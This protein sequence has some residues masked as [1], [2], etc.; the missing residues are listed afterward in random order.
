MPF[1]IALYQEKDGKLTED[2]EGR[3]VLYV[4]QAEKAINTFQAD[5]LVCHLYFVLTDSV[6]GDGAKDLRRRLRSGE[7]L[8][9]DERDRIDGIYE[10]ILAMAEFYQN[11]ITS[12]GDPAIERMMTHLR[13]SAAYLLRIDQSRAQMHE[14]PRS[15]KKLNTAMFR[16]DLKDDFREISH[17]DYNGLDLKKMVASTELDAVRMLEV[18]E[19]VHGSAVVDY[20]DR[21]LSSM[22]GKGSFF[23]RL[24]DDENIPIW[25]SLMPGQISEY[26]SGRYVPLFGLISSLTVN[27]PLCLRSTMDKDYKDLCNGCIRMM[28]PAMGRIKNRDND[29]ESSLVTAKELSEKYDKGTIDGVMCFVR[30]LDCI[31]AN[32]FNERGKVELA[33]SFRGLIR[34]L[35]PKLFGWNYNV[36]PAVFCTTSREPYETFRKGIYRTSENGVISMECV[37]VAQCEWTMGKRMKEANRPLGGVCKVPEPVYIHASELPSYLEGTKEPVAIITDLE[38]VNDIDSYL[39]SFTRVPDKA[40]V[41][42]VGIIE[43]LPRVVFINS[44][45]PFTTVIVVNR[46]NMFD[47]LTQY[48]IKL[49][50]SV[51]ESYMDTFSSEMGVTRDGLRTIEAKDIRSLFYRIFAEYAE[52]LI[53]EAKDVESHFL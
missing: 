47:L 22:E 31:F 43:E 19:N 14:H 44:M 51:A 16:H 49:M 25:E 23:V 10:D 27:A 5:M 41:K 20:Y 1:R 28:A 39:S 45:I 11:R 46:K 34:M 7:D 9:D 30:F 52:G 53:E 29:L 2:K 15:N 6:F 21:I 35:N 48:N 50:R 38:N 13:F 40:K 24:E 18:L 17:L 37:K 26:K 33:L 4:D 32:A 8:S 3:H 42:F 36:P 12:Q